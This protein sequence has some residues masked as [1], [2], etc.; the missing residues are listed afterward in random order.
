MRKIRILKPSSI[1]ISMQKSLTDAEFYF[2]MQ[3]VKCIL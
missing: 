1:D 3:K 2:P